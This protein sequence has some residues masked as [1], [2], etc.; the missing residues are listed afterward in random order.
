MAV[1]LVASSATFNS[2]FGDPTITRPAGYGTTWTAGDLILIFA[3]WFDTAS[4]ATWSGF[5]R[6]R[7]A[8]TVAC[9]GWFAKTAS[10]AEP[11]SYTSAG[12]PATVYTSFCVAL[13]GGVLPTADEGHSS[14]NTGNS[15]TRTGLSVT[16]GT[17]DALLLLGLTGYDSASGTPGG[18]TQVET[19]Q[20]VNNAW[21]QT[22]I[23]AG[24][25]GD[26]AGTGTTSAWAALMLAIDTPGG[27]GAPPPPAP[28]PVLSFGANF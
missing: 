19:D 15:T 11:A 20:D 9:G 1:Q 21:Y 3:S 23:A 24:A 22:G 7:N 6:I 26:R 14:G 10:G 16:A 13:T 18:M 12:S 2:L 8:G 28:L 4:V 5:T 27:G 17:S 25:T